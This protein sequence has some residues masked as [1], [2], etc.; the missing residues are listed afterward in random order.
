MVAGCL[1][2]ITYELNMEQ[3][4]NSLKNDDDK[5]GLAYLGGEKLITKRHLISVIAIGYYL[6][7]TLIDVVDCTDHIVEGKKKDG[8]FIAKM[9]KEVYPKRN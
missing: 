3:E 5:F 6:L 2:D 9:M 1:L 8:P 7:P 4:L